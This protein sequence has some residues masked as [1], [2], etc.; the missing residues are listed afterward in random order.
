MSSLIPQE[1]GF[2]WSM[3]DVVYGNP[4]K[5]RQPLTTFIKEVNNFPGLLDIIMSIEGLV[6]KRSSHASGVI[7]YGKDP[8]ETAAFMRTPRGDLITCYDLH[9]AEAAGKLYCRLT[10]N[11]LSAMY[12]RHFVQKVRK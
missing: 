11:R 9:N 6:N 8:Y 4:E 2:L 7:L 5:G 12:Y 10:L 1:R 3:S